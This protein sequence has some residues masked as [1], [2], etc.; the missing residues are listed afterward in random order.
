MKKDTL[1]KEITIKKSDILSGKLLM[2]DGSIEYFGKITGQTN[3]DK[4]NQDTL[5]KEILEEFG[6]KFR[7]EL[8]GS[9]GHTWYSHPD[10]GRVIKELQ[11]FLSHTIDRIREEERK[12][13]KKF[14]NKNG[15]FETIF[16]RSYTAVN[17][18]K[19]L[20]SLTPK[21]KE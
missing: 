19:L 2:K 9:D 8:Y 14:I 10:D 20:Q 5:K 11:D 6:N 7:K 12:A 13:L 3:F 21:D 16:N 1:K 18:D 4:L 17:A 15:Y